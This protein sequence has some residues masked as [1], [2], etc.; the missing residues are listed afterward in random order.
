MTAER[1]GYRAARDTIIDLD[2]AQ[3]AVHLGLDENAARKL[4]ARFGRWS[5]YR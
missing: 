3:A 5:P 2:T 4:M 1:V